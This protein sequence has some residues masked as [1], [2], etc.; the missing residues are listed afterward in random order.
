MSGTGMSD[1]HG[2]N[3]PQPPWEAD[4]SLKNV[5]LRTVLMV[6]LIAMVLLPGLGTAIFALPS[7]SSSLTSEALKS[8]GTNSQVAMEQLRELQTLRTAQLD[9]LS[10]TVFSKPMN[11]RPAAISRELETQATVLGCD[12]LLWVG[13]DGTVWGSTT[14]QVGHKLD[15]AQLD[16][17]TESSVATSVV[18]IVPPTE[19]YALGLDQ[20]YRVTIMDSP[21]G[22]ASPTEAV[23]ALAV[24]SVAPVR[25]AFGKNVG[26]LVGLDML[27][28][29]AGF[30]DQ[31][32]KK[33]GGQASI[34]Q[35]GVCVATTI[36]GSDGKRVSGMP[37]SDEIRSVVLVGGERFQGNSSVLD[38]TYI[39]DYEPLK[40]PG[41]NV[42]G[43][44][45]T[46]IPQAPYRTAGITFTV[47]F[48]LIATAG[49][50]LAI[51][52]GWTI[53]S[54]ATKPLTG[55]SEAAEKIAAGDLTVTV[56]EAGYREAVVMA[57]AFN[58]MTVALREL[59]TRVESSAGTLSG[60]AND[61]AGAS[62]SEADTATSQ[63][64]AVAQATATI[65][66]LTHSFGAVA[67]GARRVLDIAED[68]LE[69]A[70][71]GRGFI[72]TSV[73]NVE[74]LAGGSVAVAQGA[75]HLGEVAENISQVTTLIS[76][77]AEQTK[78][79][80]LNAAI[81]AARAGEAGKGFGV[82][83]VEIRTLADSV[84]TS[85]GRIAQ[86]VDGI[87]GA[88]RILT[89]TANSQGDSATTTVQSAAQTRRSFDD[90]L[91]QMERT[92]HAAREIAAA[93]Q[94]QQ[95]A[96]RQIVEVMHQVSSG[97][98]GNAAASQELA[99]SAD[100]IQREAE[101]LTRGL[102]KFR[103]H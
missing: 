72:E 45:F 85:A 24:A 52:M 47:K 42:I 14:G 102:G 2:S 43:M 29:N 22:S 16:A 10:R 87:Q 88:S 57:N 94:Q 75:E 17:A 103:T 1:T 21:D 3:L 37:A 13:T 51:G 80:A 69:A 7:F 30:V 32:V 4:L 31:V 55:I 76:S 95:A 33:V 73:I 18:S 101:S 23:G 59:L 35:N 78:I 9:S 38:V 6:S 44:M 58:A 8:A 96:S 27:K 41:G 74:M 5:S 86:L 100:N 12:Y 93:A 46:G 63:A 49:L 67:D 19:M 48:I 11:R 20:K 15:W 60:V 53:A 92:A 36:K 90:I 83:A 79:L 84:S 68:S 70:Q 82:V 40:D 54:E 91:E 98:T 62:H 64:S 65:E 77:I 50:V 61:I 99:S 66:E 28:Q 97:V 34:Y 81:E 89:E 25:N 56:P 26:A 71:Q 39:S